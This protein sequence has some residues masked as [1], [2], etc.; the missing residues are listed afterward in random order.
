MGVIAVIFGPFMVALPFIAPIS[1][2][3]AGLGVAG[4]F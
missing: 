2:L 3:I 4:A 1:A